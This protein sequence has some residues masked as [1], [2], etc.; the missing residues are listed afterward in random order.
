M[1]NRVQVLEIVKSKIDS[2][3]GLNQF[4]IQAPVMAAAPTKDGSFAEP[5]FIS[6]GDP[7][8]DAKE[9]KVHHIPGTKQFLTTVPKPGQTGSNWGP[10]PRKFVGLSVLCDARM[11]SM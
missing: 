1:T 8:T 2:T 5:T 11:Q 4:L 7:Y 6:I 10:G 9:P 3:K